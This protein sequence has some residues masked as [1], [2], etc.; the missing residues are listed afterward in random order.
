MGDRNSF[1]REIPNWCTCGVFMPTYILLCLSSTNCLHD[2]SESSFWAAGYMHL[3][4]Q[5][6]HSAVIIFFH[7]R[8][9]KHGNDLL[10]LILC[11]ILF[12]PVKNIK[13][14]YISF[15]AFI[16]T[17]CHLHISCVYI[18]KMS[19]MKFTSDGKYLYLQ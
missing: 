8:M 1:C 17:K 9:T 11:L 12:H 7:G 15:V 5:G 14:Q 16:Q 6:F 4:C 2:S 13:M 3:T 19:V 18:G 10:S